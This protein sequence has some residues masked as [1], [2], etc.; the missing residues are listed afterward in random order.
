VSIEKKVKKT[1][2]INKMKGK[3]KEI[4]KD[5]MPKT[6]KFGNAYCS[7]RMDYN[8]LHTA[9]GRTCPNRFLELRRGFKAS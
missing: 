4:K 3:R 2:K 8:R 5:N 1:V 6:E 7:V 9:Y